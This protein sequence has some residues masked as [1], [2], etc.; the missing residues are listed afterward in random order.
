MFIQ[1]WL[2][3]W[4]TCCNTAMYHGTYE[5]HG[6]LLYLDKWLH[7]LDCC[8]TVAVIRH[9]HIYIHRRDTLD[10]WLTSWGS[11]YGIY[12]KTDDMSEKINTVKIYFNSS[13][14][15]YLNR[16]MLV[17][18]SCILCSCTNNVKLLHFK[19]FFSTLFFISCWS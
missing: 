4:V 8:V 3:V 5:V 15:I 12:Q 6:T 13:V 2:H 18:K 7:V 10:C 19:W 9:V 17:I 11:T 16:L 14:G 1:T